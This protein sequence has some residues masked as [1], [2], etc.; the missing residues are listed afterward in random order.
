MDKGGQGDAWSVDG[1]PM[2]V[3]IQMTVK[4]LYSELSVPNSGTPAAFMQNQGMI[5]FL[6]VTC[7]VDITEPTFILKI[8]TMFAV[9]LNKIFDIPNNVFNEV[10]DDLRDILNPF[11]EI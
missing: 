1:L 9:F 2:Q 6:A 4:D 7:G 5:D 11:I 8:K 3:K 10:I